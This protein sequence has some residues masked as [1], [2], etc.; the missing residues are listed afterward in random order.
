MVADVGARYFTPAN[1]ARIDGIGSDRLLIRGVASLHGARHTVI[2]DRIE[3]GTYMMAAA[4]TGGEVR[5]LSEVRERI[6]RAERARTLVQLYGEGILPQAR[7]ALDSAAASYGVGK[8]EFVTL[9]GDFLSVLEAE[10]EYEAQRA[11][12]AMVLAEL[13]PLTGATLLLPAEGGEG[14]SASGGPHE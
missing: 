7:S 5:L 10:K 14:D 11:Q 3:T 2:P 8:A 1:G 9:I 4:A 6:T 13:E 12:E